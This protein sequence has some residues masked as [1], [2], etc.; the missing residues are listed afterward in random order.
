MTTVGQTNAVFAQK[1][2]KILLPY[3]ENWVVK[4][5]EIIEKRSLPAGVQVLLAVTVLDPAGKE[6]SDLLFMESPAVREKAPQA[7]PEIKLNREHLLPQRDRFSF[8]D[9]AEAGDYI[10]SAVVHLLSGQGYRARED[11]GITRLEK[12]QSGVFIAIAPACGEAALAQAQ[13]LVGLRRKYGSEPDYWLVM[14]AFQDPL[15]VP[16]REQEAWI[17]RHEEFLALH[18]IGV[19]AV[20]NLDPNSIYPFTVYPRNREL[21]KYFMHNSRRWPVVRQRYV[22]NRQKRGDQPSI[23]KDLG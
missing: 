13:T 1:G 21:L 3:P 18:R 6:V 8:T 14:L 17:S 5:I 12:E 23:N 9:P 16:M 20:D 19:Y 15:G 11:S 7:L 22:V 2:L 10:R 4:R